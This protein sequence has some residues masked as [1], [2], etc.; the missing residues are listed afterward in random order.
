MSWI[1]IVSPIV[2][3]GSAGYRLYIAL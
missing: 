2:G 3:D 1:Y